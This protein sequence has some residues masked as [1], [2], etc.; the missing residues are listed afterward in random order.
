MLNGLE[1][2]GK[3]GVVLKV[4][5]RRWNRIYMNDENACHG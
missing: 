5:Y 4:E 3:D 1:K 2:V